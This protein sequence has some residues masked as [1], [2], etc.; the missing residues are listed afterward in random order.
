[1]AEG[2]P[3]VV[4]PLEAADIAALEPEEGQEAERR[5]GGDDDVSAAVH[6]VRAR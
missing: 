4:Q 1:V 6:G 5:M 3:P 2:E